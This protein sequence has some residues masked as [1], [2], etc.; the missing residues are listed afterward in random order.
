MDVTERF[1]HAATRFWVA[2]VLVLLAT[3]WAALWALA[4]AGRFAIVHGFRFSYSK[5]VDAKQ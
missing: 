3:A 5:V 2:T 1:N 4:S